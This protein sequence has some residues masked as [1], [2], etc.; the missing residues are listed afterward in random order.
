V[1]VATLFVAAAMSFWILGAKRAPIGGAEVSPPSEAANVPEAQPTYS[2][3]Y[4]R[5]AHMAPTA[6]ED[7]VLKL[8]IL[9]DEQAMAWAPFAVAHLQ[10]RLSQT[11][12]PWAGVTVELALRAEPGWTAA[13]AWNFMELGGWDAEQPELV[14]VALGWH[15]G[16]RP[17]GKEVPASDAASQRLDVL[18]Q[19]AVFDDRGQGEHHFYL[20]RGLEGLEGEH[21]SPHHHLGL[22]DALGLRA[23]ERGATLLYVE[24]PARHVRK[25]RNFFPTT[26]SRPRPWLATVFPLEGQGEPDSL[27]VAD[28]VFEL[29]PV[30]AEQ[31][32]RYVGL[33][34]APAVLGVQSDG[35]SESD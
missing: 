6:T 5:S 27:F 24:Q 1:L 26:A 28:S 23:A 20:R 25:Q 22:L 17:R 7:G 19:Q 4:V 31:V 18:A 9:G 21:L 11:D 34:V 2:A 29:S 30:G 33:G 14:L 16:A 15:D 13:D 32:G 10:R 35:G 3:D 12:G 8:L